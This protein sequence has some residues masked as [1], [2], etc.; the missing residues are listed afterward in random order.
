MDLDSEHFGPATLFRHATK[1]LH[2]YL[3][4]RTTWYLNRMCRTTPCCEASARPSGTVWRWPITQNVSDILFGPP[5]SRVI[6]QVYENLSMND[7]HCR[8][9]SYSVATS[10][11]FCTNLLSET[12]AT[13]YKP[14][15]TARRMDV[16][17][18]Q[19]VRS[20]VGAK[21]ETRRKT[22]REYICVDGGIENLKKLKEVNYEFQLYNQLKI[23]LTS[24]RIAVI[25][26]L[27]NPPKLF[28]LW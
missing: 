23:H 15:I 21:K 1:F 25:Q 6:G 27:W 14:W 26:L 24:V 22:W 18:V 13:Y 28:P 11:I 2:E 8:R 20:T 16:G 10:Q 19:E 9:H 5:S 3:L 7:I 12:Y 17:P 4:L